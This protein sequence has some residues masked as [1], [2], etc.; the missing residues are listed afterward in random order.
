VLKKKFKTESKQEYTHTSPG[1]N[2]TTTNNRLHKETHTRL[3]TSFKPTN[4]KFDAN[5]IPGLA[6]YCLLYYASINNAAGPSA[7]RA[8]NSPNNIG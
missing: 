5:S 1:T 7:K 6:E 8:I 4:I 3:P 2:N